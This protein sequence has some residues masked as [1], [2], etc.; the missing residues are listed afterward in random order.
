MRVGKFELLISIFLLFSYTEKAATTNSLIQWG[1]TWQFSNDCTYGTFANGDYW[2]VAPVVVTN[3]T[4][5]W[6]GTNNGWEINPTVQSPQGFYN[7]PGFLYDASLRPAFP[8][9]IDTNASLVKAIGGTNIS[10]ISIIRTA[11]V[12]TVLTS[13][14]PGGGSDVF[15]PPYVGT[16]KP[17]YLVSNLK[18]NLLPN[19]YAPVANTP[20]FSVVISNFSKC[21][22]MD[23]HPTIPGYFRPFSALDDYQP[24]NTPA[25]N[26]AMLRLMLND[27]YSDKLPALIQFT[28]QAIDRAY[29][30]YYGYKQGGTGHNPNHRIVAAWAATLL[31]IT[32][33]KTFLSTEVGFHEDTYLTNGISRA[34]WGNNRDEWSYW[35]YVM[36]GVGDRSIGDPYRYIDGGAFSPGLTDY[37]GI[38]SQSFKGQALIYRLFPLLTNCIPAIRRTNLDGYAERWVTN[39]MWTSPDPVAPFDG[40]TNNY[41]VTFGPDGMGGFIAGSGRAPAVHGTYK[42]AGQYKSAFVASMWDAYVTGSTNMS[43]IMNGKATFKGKA[44]I[45]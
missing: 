37:Q 45:R 4:P 30:L 7:M 23:H 25:L 1:I 35:N 10:S 6:D 32:D 42:D 38:V 40:N 13:A 18:S 41:G 8:F 27:N 22:R 24:V 19:S 17:L 43:F 33:I 16:N 26:E 14:P 2:V 34:L 15:R 36:N 11:A 39:G 31:D 44:T 20:S 28:Q 9:T 3:M 12:L 21:L 5:D 29:C